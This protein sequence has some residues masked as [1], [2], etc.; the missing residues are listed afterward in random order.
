MNGYFGYVRVSTVRQGEKGSSLQEQQDAI[1]AY[2]RQHGLLIV[3]WFEEQETAAKCGRAAF[4]RMLKELEL[5]RA[6]GVITHKID[7]SARNLR[8]WASLGELVDRGVELHFAHESL[9]LSSRGGRLS[10]DIQAVVAADYVRNLREEVKKGFYGRLKQGLYPLNAPLGYLDQGGGRPKVVDPI[11]GPLIATAFELYATGNWS[12]FTLCAELH[13]RGLRNRN[14]RRVTRNGLATILR[15]PFYMGLIRIR[16]TGELFRGVHQPLITKP[17][18]DRVG[19]ALARKTQRAALRHCFR[20]QRLIRCARCDRALAASRV[21]GRVYYR[22][23]T[24]SC[25]TTSLREDEVDAQLKLP[26]RSLH[27][28]DAQWLALA[29]DIDSALAHRKADGD[30][31]RKGVALAIA[32]LDDRLGRLTDAYL[33]RI[34]ERDLYLARKERLLGDRADLV[35]RKAALEA[36]DGAIRVRA[37]K[38]LELVKAVQNLAILNDDIEIRQIVQETVSN[39]TA[40]GK[41]LAITW[42]NPFG[43]FFFRSPVTA[44]GPYRAELRTEAAGASYIASAVIGHCINDTEARDRG[45]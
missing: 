27:L 16:K 28:T 20:Y 13:A 12:L 34:V 4:S 18:F 3:Q 21:K 15:N 38:I 19:R 5:G 39:L 37:A 8:D 43:I 23:A 45:R 11:A 26:G 40:T 1:S 7:R 29:K 42:R 44:G 41:K 36:G 32:A 30:V 22:C 25:P 17:L 31:E 24:R 35:A 2:A 10:A 14:G 33:D 9:D 6:A